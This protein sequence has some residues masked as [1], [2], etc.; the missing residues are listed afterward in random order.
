MKAIIN[1]YNTTPWF[2]SLVQALLL[3]LASFTT[4]WNGGLPTTK[5][6][7]VALLAG[8]GGALWGTFTR[9][10]A[11]NVATKSVPVTTPAGD[12]AHI[13]DGKMVTLAKK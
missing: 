9:W 11:T 7:L 4:S 1:Y 3:A 13:T 5:A 8:L 6:A 10:L 2:H 12:Q